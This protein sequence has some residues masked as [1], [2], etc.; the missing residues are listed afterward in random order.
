MSYHAAV[1][2]RAINIPAVHLYR[3]LARS[4]LY[5]MHAPNYKLSRLRTE[6]EPCHG[7]CY[8]QEF[9]ANDGGCGRPRSHT[10]T[11]SQSQSHFRLCHFR[12]GLRNNNE[13]VTTRRGTLT[14]QKKRIKAERKHTKAHTQ[15]SA[16][17]QKRQNKANTKGK[18]R[19]YA[20]AVP[21]P[22]AVSL[23]RQPS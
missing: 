18:A 23:T 20:L 7:I 9:D 11:E 5:G 8:L 12:L 6:D 17:H 4:V 14:A 16:Q 15:A 13:V 3:S 2:F 10:P 22:A 21:R 1:A 19:T